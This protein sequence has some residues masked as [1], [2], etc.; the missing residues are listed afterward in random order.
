MEHSII[1]STGISPVLT[2]DEIRMVKAHYAEPIDILPEQQVIKGI[3]ELLN[4]GYVELGHV[5]V[6]TSR[7]DRA[8]LV[9]ATAILI[10]TD[11]IFHFPKVTFPEIQ[12]AVR[13]GL[14]REYGDY[15]GFNSLSVHFFV[16]SYLNS[17]ERFNALERQK[18]YMILNAPPKELSQEAKDE[19]MK[20]GLEQCRETYRKTGRIIDFGSVNFHMLEQSGEINLSPE[21]RLEIYHEAQMQ[22]KAETDAQST[23][24]H[25]ILTRLR[26]NDTD[27]IAIT[28]RS[29]EIALKRYFEKLE[30]SIEHGAEGIEKVTA[31]LGAEQK[32]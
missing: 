26:S 11:L 20:A 9:R 3:V 24:F 18:R 6:G 2:Q 21:E 31:P 29:K 27:Q 5:P 12:A 22:L 16:K 28:S 10:R 15:Y 13:Q 17:E 19:L 14:R 25:Q 8:T 4:R 30:K 7:H 1:K 23:S 32:I